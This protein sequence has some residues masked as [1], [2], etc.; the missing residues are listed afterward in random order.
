MNYERSYNKLLAEKIMKRFRIYWICFFLIMPFASTNATSIGRIDMFRFNLNR[1]KTY[2]NYQTTTNATVTSLSPIRE[3][4]EK[5]GIGGISAKQINIKDRCFKLAICCVL[6]CF[7]LLFTHGA[8][9]GFAWLIWIFISLS[10]L[11][12]SHNWGGS[13]R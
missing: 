10:S 9:Q 12:L 6:L 1:F 7:V 11:G 3:I 13:R 4:L 5:D 8:S 2:S